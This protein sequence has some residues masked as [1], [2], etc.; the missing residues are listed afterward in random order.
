MER[1]AAASSV[2]RYLARSNRVVA[3]THD[4]GVGDLVADAF[5]NFHFSDT[6]GG[7]GVRFD[8]QLQPGPCPTTNALKL[9]RHAGFP[10]DIVNEAERIVRGEA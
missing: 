6:V 7:D 1:V 3:A 9:L 10:A 2:L 4:L 5:D 8:Y